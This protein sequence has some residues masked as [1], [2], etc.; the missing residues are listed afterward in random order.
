MVSEY[1]FAMMIGIDPVDLG[2]PADP[3]RIAA[4]GARIL[5]RTP[6]V[7]PADGYAS[8]DGE[9]ADIGRAFLDLSRIPRRARIARMCEVV[10]PASGSYTP[11]QMTRFFRTFRQSVFAI[12]RYRPDPYAGDIT[13]L[14]HS[15]AYPFPGSREAVTDYWEELALGELD[16]VDIPGD[17]YDCLSVE[18]APRV[19]SILTHVTGGAVI[20]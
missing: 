7:M 5:E 11:E 9:F 6:G 2:F 18:H 4:A 15:G 14:R 19:L 8:L 3:W 1:S 12:T 20:A 10:P 17:N 16:I 13:F